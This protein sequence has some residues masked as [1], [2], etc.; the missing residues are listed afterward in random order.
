MPEHL[1][2][3]S[4]HVW[5]VHLDAPATLATAL[6]ACLSA[7]ERDRLEAC[8]TDDARRRFTMGRAALRHVLSLYT[9]TEPVDVRLLRG[10]YGKPLL[11]TRDDLHFSMTHSGEAALIAVAR[12]AVGVD[13]EHDRVPR[14]SDR[15]ASRL[16]HPQTV[17]VLASLPPERRDAAFLDAWTLREAHV[18]AV[19]GGLFRTPD[20]LPFDPAHPLDGV[21]R[22]LCERDGPTPWSLARFRPG[23]RLRAAVVVRGALRS[24]RTLNVGAILSS[25]TDVNAATTKDGSLT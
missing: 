11:D 23:E 15:I 7:D 9:G 25:A 4:V 22:S 8:V 6:A 20:V 1:A 16:F 10:E 14:R 18:K 19:G 2:P 12:A 17:L 5:S 24:V 13:M 3:L 21:P